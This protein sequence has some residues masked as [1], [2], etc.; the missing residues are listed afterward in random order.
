MRQ[1]MICS[2]CK[3][4][5]RSDEV[6]EF[7][8]DKQIVIV[9]DPPF[10]VGWGYRT[11]KDKLPDAQYW[12]MLKDTVGGVQ[13][14]VMI[15][16]P[17]RL[18]RLS[19]ELGRCPSRVVSWTY[20]GHLPRQHRDIAYYG[21]KPDFSLVRQPYKNPND[22]RIKAMI[23]A[24][25]KGARLYDW[26]NIEQVKNVS[27]E[28]RNHPCQMPL[29][30]MRN[31]IG[32]IPDKDKIVVIDPFMGTGTTGVACKEYDVD[33]IGIDIDEEYVKIRADRMKEDR[34]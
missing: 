13:K 1:L 3:D 28:K 7:V 19:V 16:Y 17:E 22:K 21:I 4:A 31:V 25:S 15:H 12:Q 11:Y 6:A 2:D 5:L 30:V 26:W 33:F 32:I 10:N 34:T 8:G 9:T 18:H 23:E 20:N 27:K 14:L 29:A 24:G